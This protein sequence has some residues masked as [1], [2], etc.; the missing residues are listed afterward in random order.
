M[1][2]SLH[3]PREVDYKKKRWKKQKIA[4]IYGRYYYINN[5]I[6]VHGLEAPVKRQIFKLD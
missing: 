1:I 2:K 6:S 5:G 4:S 3:L